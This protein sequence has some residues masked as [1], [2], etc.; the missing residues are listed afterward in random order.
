M[1]V[2]L[3]NVSESS[4]ADNFLNFVAVADL[5]T[6]LESIIPFLV[7]ETII[8]KSLKLGW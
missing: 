8:N 3:D 2:A 7:I 6:L 1:I 4:L 5:I